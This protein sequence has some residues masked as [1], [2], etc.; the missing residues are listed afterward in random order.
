MSQ[1]DLRDFLFKLLPHIHNFIVAQKQQRHTE[2]ARAATRPH[3]TG[4]PVFLIE[5]RTVFVELL[6]GRNELVFVFGKILTQFGRVQHGIMRTI[7]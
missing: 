3:T 2:E 6:H 1:I 5:T 4:C 7:W